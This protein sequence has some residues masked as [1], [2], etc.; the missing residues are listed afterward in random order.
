M[1]AT[2][3]VRGGHTW[4][5]DFEMISRY[6][7]ETEEVDAIEVPEPGLALGLL[8]GALALIALRWRSPRRR[9]REHS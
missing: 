1:S 4:N 5:T 8:P 2:F 6:P 9:D 7:V 3:L